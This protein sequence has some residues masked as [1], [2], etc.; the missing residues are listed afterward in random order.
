MSTNGR[1]SR[2][3]ASARS[4]GHFTARPRHIDELPESVF[5][6]LLDRSD[7]LAYADNCEP[8]PKLA[9]IEL[10]PIASALSGALELVE[11]SYLRADFHA[12]LAD[13]LTARAQVT[14]A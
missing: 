13:L 4:A 11:A 12:A 10:N 6:V 3:A 14:A 8:P 2:S 7:W 5:R 1:R 9:N